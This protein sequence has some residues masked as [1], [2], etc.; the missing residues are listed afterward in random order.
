VWAF[1]GRS[2]H[3]MNKLAVIIPFYK[4]KEI[5]SLCFKHL[6]TQQNKFKF[7]VFVSG[8]DYTIVPKS[9]KVVDCD[10]LPLGNKLNTLLQQTKAYDGVIIL[11]SDDFIS[12]SIFELYKSIDTTKL[13]YYGFDNC[14]LYSVWSGKLGTDFSYTKSGNT[15]GVARLWTKPTLELMNYSLWTS[16][17]NNGLDTDSKM[18]MTS[19]GIKEISLPYSEHFILDVKHELNITNPAIVNTSDTFLD[20]NEIIARFGSVG[21]DIL[22]L[23][24]KEVKQINKNKMS[25]ELVNFISNGSF[26][27]KGLY[28]IIEHKAAILEQKGYGK[29]EREK[30]VE[31][32]KTTRTIKAK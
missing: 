8:D 29:I 20:V 3:V 17:K 28:K 22:D 9:F 12:D 21:N 32:P 16:R 11:G 31:K 6:A 4:R 30:E 1:G 25:K 14:H 10:N 7:D 26:M 24:I 19:K 15:I 13:V 2:R 5:T 23:Q 27:A 18:N